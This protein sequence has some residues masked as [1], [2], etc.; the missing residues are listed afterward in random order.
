ME[1]LRQVDW[2]WRV[3]WG[4]WPIEGKERQ[5]W[6]IVAVALM[7]IGWLMSRFSHLTTSMAPLGIITFELACTEENAR[8]IL[9][10]WVGDWRMFG[11]INNLFLNFFLI[12]A[13]M[14]L[15]MRSCFWAQHEMWASTEPSLAPAVTVPDGW[16][17]I[18]K[19][20][21]ARDKSAQSHADA[22]HADGF[23]SRF[24]HWHTLINLAPVLAVGVLGAGLLDCV[25]NVLLLKEIA[26][27]EPLAGG[28]DDRLPLNAC[29]LAAVKFVLLTFAVG[30]IAAGFCVS[31]HFERLRKRSAAK[32]DIFLLTGMSFVLPLLG[33]AVL[34]WLPQGQEAMRVLG[35]DGP[36]AVM[37]DDHRT[38]VV[39]IWRLFAF[40]F[41]AMLLAWQAWFCARALLEL[42]RDYLDPQYPDGTLRN[43]ANFWPYFCAAL[44]LGLISYAACRA[45]R[46]QPFVAS[47]DVHKNGWS[48]AALILYGMA[49][50]ILVVGIL[51]LISIWKQ[52][53][54]RPMVDRLA[55][56]LPM[57]KRG[58]AAGQAG[59][60]GG[61]EPAP[62]D[63][64]VQRVALERVAVHEEV[65]VQE[66]P[67][68]E[69]HTVRGME[70]RSRILMGL[71]LMVSPIMLFLLVKTNYAVASYIGPGAL[72]LGSL[73]T[74]IPLG[75]LLIFWRERTKV[76]FLS[77]LLLIAFLSSYLDINDNHEI[78]FEQ[79]TVSGDE[80]PALQQT[81]NKW[82]QQR[83]TAEGYTSSNTSSKSYPVF[84]VAAEGGGLRAAY[85][86]GTA[87]THLQQRHPEF[88]NHIFAMSGVSGGSVGLTAFGALCEAYPGRSAPEKEEG[89]AW[90]TTRNRLLLGQDFLSPTLAAMLYGETLQQIL[91]IPFQAL[92][93]TRGLEGSLNSAWR[94]AMWKESDLFPDPKRRTPFE[95]PLQS[96]RAKEVQDFTRGGVPALFLNTTRVETGDRLALN[97]IP[98]SECDFRHNL[99]TLSD[100]N[101]R[102]K[103]TR[104]TA[105]F[106]SARFPYISPSGSMPVYDLTMPER[107]ER[108]EQPEAQ[109][110][111]QPGSQQALNKGE[112]TLNNV[113]LD[114]K[115][116]VDGG[117]YENS[118]AATLMD[119]YE[120]L[121]RRPS[122][123]GCIIYVVRIGFNYDPEPAGQVGRPSF[124]GLDESLV[125]LKTLFNTRD[126]RART[127]VSRLNSA[128]DDD[129]YN[130]RLID[131]RFAE[132]GVPLTTDWQLSQLAMQNLDEQA[133]D[134]ADKSP[135]GYDDKGRLLVKEIK[136]RR[137]PCPKASPMSA[138]MRA[139]VR[140]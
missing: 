58:V 31:P 44:P 5:A 92:D 33:A 128:L 67:G 37:R 29:R 80:R 78:Q 76:P 81:F 73:A 101:P 63:S 46:T 113:A 14:L 126:A 23:L 61:E 111:A 71:S 26:S 82:L 103:I 124:A 56:K 96:W 132:G 93:R 137:R 65:A 109:P 105:A 134:M 138:A 108:A 55:A 117:Y 11:A 74:F 102:I 19:A 38:F 3:G 9:R 115:R 140:N 21:F 75:S 84:L 119:I 16:R 53:A 49:V 87:L 62:E 130:S 136:P 121:S 12:P 17:R 50:V 66:V 100:E 35:E 39:A 127:A 60:R 79:R 54:L 4:Q 110:E 95:T 24:W 28:L 88:Y 86:A 120:A 112:Q 52:P 129:E 98:A 77:L 69:H 116:Y 41:A 118:G 133:R 97:S 57:R 107:A 51:L 32:L 10:S 99:R 43:I 8:M 122:P 139:P 104:A 7:L 42:E 123:R 15:F 135:I 68:R 22:S 94:R 125:P 20:L 64:A 30:Y 18:W 59:Q 45:A 89:D 85:Q 47:W 34:V 114:K 1:S 40:G 131:F 91:P 70:L 25:E 72:L 48:Q 36:G 27:W 83:R 90:W 106:L 6:W 13:Y 2:P